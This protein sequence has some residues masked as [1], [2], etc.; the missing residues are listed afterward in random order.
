MVKN[1]QITSLSVEEGN[2]PKGTFNLSFCTWQER[3]HTALIWGCIGFGL[4]Q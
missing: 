3:T 4:L 1:K 2:N